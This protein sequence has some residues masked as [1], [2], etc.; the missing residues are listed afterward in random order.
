MGFRSP[1]IA[2]SLGSLRFA[3][4]PTAPPEGRGL[5]FRP[6]TEQRLIDQVI[7]ILL[8]QRREAKQEPVIRHKGRAQ[9]D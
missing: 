7:A 6:Y 9:G 3:A 4:Q 1:E 5:L 2:G 8:R